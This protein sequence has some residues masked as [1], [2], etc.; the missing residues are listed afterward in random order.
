[1]WALLELVLSLFGD[2]LTAHRFPYW[3]D[4]DY[5]GRR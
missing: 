1:M 2:L 4:Q 3:R 5:G